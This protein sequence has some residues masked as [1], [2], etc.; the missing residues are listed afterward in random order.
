MQ[1]VD[2]L[3]FREKA[4]EKHLIFSARSKKDLAGFVRHRKNHPTH[5]QYAFNPEFWCHVWDWVAHRKLKP[6][7]GMAGNVA[8]LLPI[9]V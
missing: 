4:S 7:S 3:G 1:N 8:A 2:T 6:T 5:P 9:M